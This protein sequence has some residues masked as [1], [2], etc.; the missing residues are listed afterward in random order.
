MF[1]TLLLLTLLYTHS[2]LA[3]KAKFYEEY[4]L[5]GAFFETGEFENCLNLPL[6]IQKNARSVN[7]YG[8]C[9]VLHKNANCSDEGKIVSNGTISQCDNPENLTS[10]GMDRE[11]M[12]VNACYYGRDGHVILASC[13]DTVGKFEDMETRYGYWHEEISHG[14]KSGIFRGDKDITALGDSI[15]LAVRNDEGT[16]N[17]LSAAEFKLQ[18]SG[19]STS[20]FSQ[21][22]ARWEHSRDRTFTLKRTVDQFT[23]R[24]E[25]VFQQATAYCG[26][27]QFR[28]NYVRTIEHPA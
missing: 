5:K 22:N 27:I 12:S 11:V 20:T 4:E 28:F 26:N 1:L 13:N 16:V 25:I 14:Y 10:C 15:K 3:S 7:S 21:S 9:I 6:Y 2:S 17:I 24:Q 8:G 19:N 18:I 23:T